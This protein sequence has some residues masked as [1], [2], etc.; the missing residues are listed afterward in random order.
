MFKADKA[1]V[2]V[3]A[4]SKAALQYAFDIVKRHGTYVLVSQPPALSIPFRELI[5][6]NVAVVG[7]LQGNGEDLQET[8]DFVDQHGVKIHTTTW[9]LED[10]N[11]MWEAQESPSHAGKNVVLL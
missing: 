4:E 10:V 3:T 1:A 5:F 7:T 11:E 2:V 8:I 9:G 6:K